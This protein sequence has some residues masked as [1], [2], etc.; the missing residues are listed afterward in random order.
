MSTTINGREFAHFTDTPVKEITGPHN[1]D[2][3]TPLAV[4][5]A[6]VAAW[7]MM[8][9]R[10]AYSSLE[11][12]VAGFFAQA[13]LVYS[14][15][16]PAWRAL[17]AFLTQATDSMDVTK[18]PR[19]QFSLVA[20]ETIHRDA[21]EQCITNLSVGSDHDMHQVREASKMVIWWDAQLP[22]VVGIPLLAS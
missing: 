22:A 6:V 20:G 5:H 12:S 2:P 8:R 17:H 16:N 3:D 21:L 18:R 19:V 1:L 4:R 11:Q 10:S 13:G 15:N 14:Y 7:H 9:S